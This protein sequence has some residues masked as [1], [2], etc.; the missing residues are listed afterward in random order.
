MNCVW[1]FDLDDTLYP[2]ISFVKSGFAAVANFLSPKCNSKVE[3]LEAHLLR[4]LEEQGRGKVFN[5]LLE[6]RSIRGVAVPELL[7]VYRYHLPNIYPHTAT[8]DLL[9]HVLHVTG[10]KPH[11]VTDGHR[12]VQRSKVRALGIGSE[13]RR[14]WFTRD[15]GV[16]NEK[17][18]PLVFRKIAEVEGVSEGSLIYVGDD[19]SK[20]FLAVNEMGGVTIRV[21]TG[22]HARVHAKGAGAPTFEVNKLGDVLDFAV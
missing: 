7:K 16:K 14:C 9:S 17:P 6:E 18:S 21:K 3:E 11:L 22:R 20:D 19:P 12:L 10:R 8:Q 2:E 5:R 4:I 13:F 15:F 1:V